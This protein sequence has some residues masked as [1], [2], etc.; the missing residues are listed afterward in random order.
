MKRRGADVSFPTSRT[1]QAICADPT[2]DESKSRSSTILLTLLKDELEY[3]E[4][5]SKES[6]SLVRSTSR[7]ISSF[8]ANSTR[9]GRDPETG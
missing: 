1:R 6:E 5:Y 4:H 9:T 2:E 7:S 3:I 8:A